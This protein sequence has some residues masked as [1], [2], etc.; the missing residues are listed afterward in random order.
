MPGCMIFKDAFCP[1]KQ[2]TDKAIM[3]DL[4]N[5]DVASQGELPGAGSM[6]YYFTT[7]FPPI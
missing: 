4:A 6:D 1:Q 7:S 3:M 2:L 5:G